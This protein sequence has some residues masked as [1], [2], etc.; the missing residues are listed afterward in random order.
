MNLRPNGEYELRVIAR[1]ADGLSEPS[2]SS[3]IIH[4]KPSV[5]S[6]SSQPSEAVNAMNPPGQP[7]VICE[8]L[9]FCNSDYYYRRNSS[10]KARNSMKYSLVTYWLK[11]V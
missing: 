1:S 2:P 9:E 5:P 6:R 4:L 8:G 7:Q 10:M 3:G 11:G